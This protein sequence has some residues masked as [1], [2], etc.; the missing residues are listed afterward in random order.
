MLWWRSFRLPSASRSA[1]LRA[2]HS[3]RKYGS[4]DRCR[5][6]KRWQAPPYIYMSRWARSCLSMWQPH[7]ALHQRW[8]LR[9][10]NCDRPSMR[11]G[12]RA[13]LHDSPLKDWSMR[14]APRWHPPMWE[15]QQAILRTKE[16]CQ[17]RTDKEW[18]C[19]ESADY[20]LSASLTASCLSWCQAPRG[21]NC[22][23]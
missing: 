20:P 3:P 22:R 8:W 14:G 21:T 1:E 10:K 6:L 11:K 15:L 4:R 2:R 23:P 9:G 13:I 12:K 18:P 5:R 7:R 17:P 19:R 16:R